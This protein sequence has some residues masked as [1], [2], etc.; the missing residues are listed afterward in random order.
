M[1]SVTLAALLAAGF[2]F[3]GVQRAAAETPAGT[4][5]TNTAT[6]T[7]KDP[8]NNTYS[9]QSN[10]VTTI[11]QNAPLFT[12]TTNG[13]TTGGGSSTQNGTAYAYGDAT[14]GTSPA[15]VVPGAAV[16]LGSTPA[17]GGTGGD[18]YTLTNLGNVNGSAASPA[19]FQI[20]SATPANA[21]IQSYTITVSG[22]LTLPAQCGTAGAT[23]ATFATL[24]AANTTATAP[25]VTNT[26]NYCLYFLN[27]PNTS[28]SNAVSI[29]ANYTANYNATPG[30]NAGTTVT[31]TLT[32]LAPTSNPNNLTL[33]TGGPWSNTY[34]DPITA[35][36][37]LSLTK[38]SC[39]QGGT[40][41][42]TSTLPASGDIQYTIT[43]T[44]GGANGT[45]YTNISTDFGTGTLPASGIVALVDKVPTFG[46]VPLT[47]ETAGGFGPKVTSSSGLAPA[48]SPPTVGIYYTTAAS[49]IASGATWTS[50]G[51]TTCASIT[52][53]PTYFAVII[54]G[55]TPT[56][57]CTTA[58]VQCGLAAAGSVQ[59]QFVVKQPTGAGSGDAGSV[60]NYAN[61]A[62]GS[63]AQTTCLIGPG[64]AANTA[65]A[66]GTTDT[67][68]NMLGL[69]N[70]AFTGTGG[71]ASTLVGQS[72]QTSD[73][74]LA[75]F[76]VFTGPVTVTYTGT[77]QT[78]A[79]LVT[80]CGTGTASCDP[81]TVGSYNGTTTDNNNDFTARGFCSINGTTLNTGL[82]GSPVLLSGCSIPANG[83]AV[84]NSA[85]N[86]GNK[87][88]TINLTVV[89]P[90]GFTAK[91]CPDNGGTPLIASCTAGTLA[92]PAASG[93]AFV[94]WVLYTP[95]A[96][97]YT[98]FT[99]YDAVVTAAS[100]GNTALTNTTHNDLYAGF[101]TLT[102][103]NTVTTSGC[104]SGVTQQT[105][106]GTYV[107][108]SGLINYTLTYQNV[109]YGGTTQTGTGG[110]QTAYPANAVL[111]AT[112]LVIVED[113]QAKAGSAG[114]PQVV[115][116]GTT[117]GQVILL[118]GTAANNWGTFGT[119]NGTPADP[120][121]T[122][123]VNTGFITDTIATL[124]PRA[125]GT[126]TFTV[127]VN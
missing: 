124:A 125:N 14:K 94:Y 98:P 74:A 55:G 51:G 12:I 46:G 28:P 47:V 37:Q 56:P 114:S 93:A 87:N 76:S 43:S 126:L 35:D 113:G 83:I 68:A 92:T 36:A 34:T 40:T 62:I 71:G 5:I 48:S 13:L 115:P 10:T 64:A 112:N 85:I 96:V 58:Q 23:T 11:V 49:P 121:G 44:N 103:T 101:V 91:I 22:G 123:V 73:M 52:G 88:D 18:V 122:V 95:N 106:G 84:P 70:A 29:T 31:A 102:K 6:A 20:S 120:A 81:E 119:I 32:Y 38:A 111:T 39:Q 45:H 50:C 53:T 9:T 72:N 27:V 116:S 59:F 41:A 24:G 105:T 75:T 118:A 69:V 2:S 7:Y 104:P 99:Q 109:A 77:T 33:Q 3:G 107:C 42:C 17:A 82:A 110:F 117:P 63:N 60:K 78:P 80:G 89:A 15:V 30:N 21:T 57:A 90:A 4:A 16:P 61:S 100:A 108:P 65:N 127:K 1:K 26:L 8:A 67:S 54:S 25:T 66:C 97:S 79:L 19:F 86:A